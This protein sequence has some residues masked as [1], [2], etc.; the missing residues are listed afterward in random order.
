MAIAAGKADATLRMTYLRV[1]HNEAVGI[2]S[3][4]GKLLHSDLHHN[5]TNP[6]FWGYSAAAVKSIKEHE[7]AYN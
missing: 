5:G 3:M 7:A 2:S 4:N 1:H 6:D